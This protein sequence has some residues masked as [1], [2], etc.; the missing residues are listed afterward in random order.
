MNVTKDVV[1]DLL[2]AYLSGEASAD[3]RALVEE[4]AARD[5]AVARLLEAARREEGAPGLQGPFVLPPNLER[6]SVRR[7]RAA[8]RWRGWLLALA[9]T[10]TLLPLSFAFHGG[11]VTFVLFLDE[12]ASR[13][14]WLLAPAFW[15]GYSTLGRRLIKF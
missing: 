11:H 13:V 14:L 9:I 5:P 2:P 12:P 10:C 3:T 6:E 1:N 15:W 4:M 7:T 8:L